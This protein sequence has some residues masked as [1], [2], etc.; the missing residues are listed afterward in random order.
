M[1]VEMVPKVQ[2]LLKKHTIA[3]VGLNYRRCTRLALFFFFF[4][5]FYLSGLIVLVAGSLV[6]KM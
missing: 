6:V 3:F 5:L 4:S 1:V 2:C